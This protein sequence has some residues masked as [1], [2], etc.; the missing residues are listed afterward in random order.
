MPPLY[1]TIALLVFAMTIHYLPLAIGPIASSLVQLSPRIE[2]AARGLGRGRGR[3]LPHD[4]D[5]RSPAAA[6][7]AGAA[8]VFLHAMKELP[9]TLILSPIGFETLA[10][11]IWT[12]TSLGFYEASAI[13]ALVLLAVAAVPVYLLSER[14]A[15]PP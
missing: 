3:G 8:L 12:Q 9:V 11:D 5:R 10:T 6:C 7:M 14:G 1:Q 15:T 2:E 4:H 13:P